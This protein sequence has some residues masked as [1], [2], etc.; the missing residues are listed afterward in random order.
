[1]VAPLFEGTLPLVDVANFLT[2]L[3]VASSEG[4]VFSMMKDIYYSHEGQYLKSPDTLVFVQPRVWITYHSVQITYRHG[5]LDYAVGKPTGNELRWMGT[6]RRLPYWKSLFAWKS[7][8]LTNTIITNTIKEEVAAIYR[9]PPINTSQL[10]KLLTAQKITRFALAIAATLE[11]TLLFVDFGT[12]SAVIALFV[13]GTEALLFLASGI[14][15][16]VAHEGTTRNMLVWNYLLLGIVLSVWLIATVASFAV[17]SRSTSL[18]ASFGSSA[19]KSS[20]REYAV[21]MNSTENA[22][23]GLRESDFHPSSPF[24]PFETRKAVRKQ[25]NQSSRSEQRNVS[26]LAS[27]FDGFEDDTINA[28]GQR[29]STMIEDFS[30]RSDEATEALQPRLKWR[31][32]DLLEQLKEPEETPGV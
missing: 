23:P 31:I 5:L 9:N 8:D 18:S 4:D 30:M 16:V 25:S 29:V 3:E 17:R 19:T 2:T 21:R 15:M 32:D 26:G 1:M 20:F 6:G 28:P 7:S 12:P 14:L 13:H 11:F 10:V 22:L 27:T 24:D